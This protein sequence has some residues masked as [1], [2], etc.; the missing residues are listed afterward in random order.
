MALP[1]LRTGITEREYADLE[2]LAPHRSEYFDGQMYAMS[3]GT[4]VH[5]GLCAAVLHALMSLVDRSRCRVF[6][7]NLRVR[8]AATG[9]QTYPDASVVCGPLQYWE[10][11]RDCIEN[12]TLLVEVLSPGTAAYDR[13]FKFDNYRLIPTLREYALVWQSRERIEVFRRERDDLWSHHVAN[14]R[15]AEAELTC[16][17]IK[18]KL[19][20]I[21]AGMKLPRRADW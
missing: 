1:L 3:G 17:G 11:R 15:S 4:D 14:G 6:E 9:L 7:S 13:A 19:A 12:P 2:E 16:L 5:S 21:Y 8:V 18:L 20:D 10:Q